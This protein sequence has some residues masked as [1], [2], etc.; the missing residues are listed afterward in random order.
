MNHTPHLIHVVLAAAGIVVGLNAA[1][2]P[3]PCR[4]AAI[5]KEAAGAA[6][7]LSVLDH[8]VILLDARSAH[9]A[10]DLDG[11]VNWT[12]WFVGY[13]ELEQLVQCLRGRVGDAD[14]LA[15][16]PDEK[17]G[18]LARID[19]RDG[20]KLFGQALFVLFGQLARG[21]AAL[22]VD[23]DALQVHPLAQLPH[24]QLFRCQSR[25]GGA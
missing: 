22:R 2:G 7:C 24:P 14:A 23:A 18:A 17:R 20:A 11:A 9:R 8:A 15:V 19:A 25:E 13:N 4:R 6:V 21:P 3:P 1:P 10:D 5:E 12:D 16:E